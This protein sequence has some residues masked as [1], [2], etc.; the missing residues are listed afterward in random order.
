M[1]DISQE[2]SNVF[3]FGTIGV[4]LTATALAIAAVMFR[5]N[6]LAKKEHS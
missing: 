1:P 6:Q 4:V 5:K 3:I 2:V